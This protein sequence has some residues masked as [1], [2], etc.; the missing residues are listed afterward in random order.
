MSGAVGA[1]RIR[2]KLHSFQYDPS[3]IGEALGVTPDAMI[4]KGQQMGS[5]VANR[6]SW[7]GEFRK[8]LGNKEF[9]SALEDLLTLLEERKSFIRLLLEGGGEMIVVLSQTVAIDDGVLF[10]LKL[11]PFFLH[12]C[13]LHGVG[14][15]VEAWSPEALSTISQIAESNAPAEDLAMSLLAWKETTK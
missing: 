3:K 2:V 14:L 12:R 10:S 8:G 5:I 1:F 13:G 15:E 9:G 6:A 11:Q 4:R 7:F